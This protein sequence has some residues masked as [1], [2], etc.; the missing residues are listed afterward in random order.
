MFNSQSNHREEEDEMRQSDPLSSNVLVSAQHIHIPA[1]D[2]QQ[3]HELSDLKSHERFQHDALPPSVDYSHATPSTRYQFRAL[4]R[5]ALSYHRRQ[6]FTSVCCLVVWPVLL[7]LLSFVM[8][9][10]ENGKESSAFKG[11][12]AFCVN[13]VDPNTSLDFNMQSVPHPSNG[14]SELN[15][16]WYRPSFT[17]GADRSS[18]PLPCVRWFGESYP[19]KV[20]YDN[21]T[22]TDA[23][24]PS[25]YYTPPPPGGWFKLHEVQ[26]TWRQEKGEFGSTPAMWKLGPINQTI[27]YVTS[28]G[29]VA[30]QLGTVPDVTH[31]FLSESWPPTNA[32]VVYNSTAPGVK[33]GTGLLGAIPVRYADS[34]RSMSALPNGANEYK[35]KVEYEAQTFS[36]RPDQDSLDQS[37]ISLVK[38]LAAS[39][40]LRKM[41]N[42]PFGAIIFDALDP[43]TSSINM[44]MQFGQPSARE[45][46]EKVTPPGLRQIIT[47]A[48]MSGAMVKTKYA[49]KYLISQGLRALP[50]KWDPKILEGRT[51]NMRSLALFPFGLSFLLPTFVSILVQEKEHRHRMMMAM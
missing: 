36:Q 24:E 31:S 19:I 25:A 13:E 39:S 2:L 3:G 1:D 40:S 23:A 46:S 4:A 51:L 38:D 26:R 14:N 7:V 34:D 35:T 29:Q 5:R 37:I 28:N 49:G 18:D 15:V 20:P 41:K 42:M 12:V 8:T 22:A 47:M 48:Q 6:R 43:A 30:Q 17:S 44:T 45:W 16:A 10:I 11:I 9:L 32:S 33:P 50:Y 21:T 27:F